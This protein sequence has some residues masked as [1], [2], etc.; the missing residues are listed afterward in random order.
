MIKDT[1]TSKTIEHIQKR[2]ERER[3][4]RKQAE[5]LL[6]NKTREIYDLNKRL[7]DRARLME[8][9]IVNAQDGVIITDADLDNGG[10]HI[11]FVNE[12]FCKISGYTA[13]EVIGQTPRIL[14]GPDT[15]RNTLNKLKEKLSAGE[16]FQGEL[17]N[18][19][20][21][22]KAYWLA[23]SVTPVKDEDG[24]ITHYTAIERDVTERK[25]FE[26]ELTINREA[27]EV[28]N[29]TKSDFLANMSHELRTPMNGIIGLSELL[30]SMKLE[31]DQDELAHA[32]NS[33]SQNLLILLNDILDL[34]KI[35]A[36]ELT[37][38][39]IPFDLNKA[40]NQT[41]DLLRPLASRKSVVLEKT[42][43][44][45]IP[46]WIYGDSVRMQQVMKNLISN[47]VKFT[48]SGY[49]RLYVNKTKDKAGDPV[50]HIHVEDTGIGIP[51]DKQESIFNKFTQAD[52]STT[53]KYGGTGLGLSITKELVEMMGGIITFDSVE[54]KGT[55]FYV[56]IPIEIAEKA[57]ITEEDKKKN[58]SV[59]GVNINSN[60]L[61]VDD[62][63]VNLLYMRKVLKK[64]GFENVD[65]AK[66][67]KHA[68]EKFHTKDYDLI[69]MDCQ[70]P[71]M[72]GFEAAETIREL[73]GNTIGCIPIVAVTA[74]AMKG[75][76]E[77]CI[78]AGMNDYL[79]KPVD[80]EKLSN[81]LSKYLENQE[82]IA[83]FN[84][85][86]EKTEVTPE[87]H[88]SN[89]IPLDMDH[90]NL[91]FEDSSPEE[92]QELTELFSEQADI[93]IQTMQ[94]HCLSGEQEEWRKAAHKLKGSAANLGAIHLSETC[95]KAEHNMCAETAT[96]QSIL[97]TVITD[98]KELED[99]LRQNYS[100]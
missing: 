82:Q 91:M 52:V 68:L 12:A 8:A 42:I 86:Q 19:T 96:K 27:A 29:R 98:L 87:A 57:P 79:S 1:E 3:S 50:L 76:R 95:L 36:N 53:R 94:E 60:I 64:L 47:A 41:I 54:G 7:N 9:A 97:K 6:E 4:A 14:Q 49:I 44:Q 81:F 18:Y 11:I 80:A 22:G 37:L 58:E 15:D 24:N 16:A 66:S 84:A 85:T 71:E 25:A 26:K 62:H 17:K 32:I 23:I 93:C 89:H 38:E 20:K 48:E 100:S 90:F 10:P 46:D 56:E 35:E 73:E 39:Y 72:D 83:T 43:S 51:D 21:D 63:P 33:S 13:E 61:V 65:E 88:N 69:F 31:E 99:Y 92:I 67:G 45:L 2:L 55:T 78:D 34:S 77:R 40:I 59:T 70:M 75:A 30:C 5:T 74:D 28:A